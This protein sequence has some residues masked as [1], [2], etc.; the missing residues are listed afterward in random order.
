M[1]CSDARHLIHLDVGCDLRGAEEIQLSEHVTQCSECRSYRTG[2][3]RAMS[4]LFA[5][6]DDSPVPAMRSVWPKVSREIQRRL[7]VPAAARRFNLQVAALSVCSLSLAVVTIVHS[8]SSFRGVD[9]SPSFVPATPVLSRPVHT[10]SR[11]AFD[12]LASDISSRSFPDQPAD[13]GIGAQSF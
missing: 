6:R 2:V 11:E 5:V 10:F 12:P 13:S 7:P 1:N 4:A 3:A 9:A 8:L